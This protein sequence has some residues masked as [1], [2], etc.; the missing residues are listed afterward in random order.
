[1]DISSLLNEILQGLGVV[2]LAIAITA[3]RKLISWMGLKVTQDQANTLNTVA[4]N[5]LDWAIAQATNLIAEKGWDHPSVK[6]AVIQAA[7]S[8][9]QKNA[10]GGLRKAGIDTSAKV[11]SALALQPILERTF[12]GA[13]D[14]AATSPASPAITNKG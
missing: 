1:M 8:Y 6:A 2:V 9:A 14:K 11:K 4:N 7:L 5:A 13:M 12:S 10:E 3:G